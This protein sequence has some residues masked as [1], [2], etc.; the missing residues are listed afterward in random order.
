MGRNKE[1]LLN[2]HGAAAGKIGRILEMDG[3][4]GCRA[5]SAMSAD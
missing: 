3:G 2:G 1:L 4:D 5:R